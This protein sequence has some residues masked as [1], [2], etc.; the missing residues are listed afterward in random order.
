[1]QTFGRWMGAEIANGLGAQA[2]GC[3]KR[4]GLGETKGAH[5]CEDVS[6]SRDRVD[7]Y[8]I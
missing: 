4:L 5:D 3:C 2:G 7:V 6:K 1:M 8:P